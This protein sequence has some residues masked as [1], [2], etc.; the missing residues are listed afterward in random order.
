MGDKMSPRQPR[1]P[2]YGGQVE[3]EPNGLGGGA[4]RSRS[5]YDL[6]QYRG[7]RYPQE[8]DNCLLDPSRYPR[9]YQAGREDEDGQLY[10]DEEN[11]DFYRRASTHGSFGRPE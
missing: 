2:A 3:I 8:I 1:Q 7:D 9:G 11:Y 4:R 5:P 6:Q 10:E